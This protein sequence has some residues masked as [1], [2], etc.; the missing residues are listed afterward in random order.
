MLWVKSTTEIKINDIFENGKF[1]IRKA[2]E[3]STFDALSNYIFLRN[4]K[5]YVSPTLR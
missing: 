4:K 3:N 1:P 2:I 5:S